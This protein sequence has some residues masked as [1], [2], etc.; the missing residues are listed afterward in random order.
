MN[1][2]SNK[3]S[4]EQYDILQA[5]YFQLQSSYNASNRTIAEKDL[6][7]DQLNSK[8]EYMKKYEKDIKKQLE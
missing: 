8:I 3:Y 6:E 1:Y 4:D 2:Q 5:Q 7:I